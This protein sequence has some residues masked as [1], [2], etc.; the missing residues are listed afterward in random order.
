MGNTEG[1]HH[2]RNTSHIHRP[3]RLFHA[4][5]GALIGL[6]FFLPAPVMK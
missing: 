1:R 2:G 5:A 6:H 4:P 3:H